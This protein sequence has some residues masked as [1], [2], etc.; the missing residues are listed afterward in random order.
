LAAINAAKASGAEASK[1]G[2]WKKPGVEPRK[3]YWEIADVRFGSNLRHGG[4]VWR[5][6]I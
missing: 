2:R 1:L 6:P 4:I 5:R 3:I